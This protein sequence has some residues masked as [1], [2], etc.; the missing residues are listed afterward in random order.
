[1]KTATTRVTAKLMEVRMGIQA[2][3]VG[4][5]LFALSVITTANADEP[6]G[7][8]EAR[9][10]IQSQ[11]QAFQDEAVTTAYGFAAPNI[12]RIFPTPEVFG[13]MVRN[14]Y[15]MVWD[16]AETDFLQAEQRGSMIVQRLRLVDQQGVPYIAEYAM[17]MVDGEWRIAGVEIKKDTSYGV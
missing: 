1:M 17:L 2:K 6:S 16:P 3:I 4:G 8:D 9:S 10:V 15:P 5:V 12:R 13:K 14:T 11:L 7:A